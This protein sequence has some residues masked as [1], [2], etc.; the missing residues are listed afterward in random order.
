MQIY[1]IH[2]QS[3]KTNPPR[4]T[5]GC[6]IVSTR[7]VSEHDGQVFWYGSQSVIHSWWNMWEHLGLLDSHTLSPLLKGLSHNLQSGR[8]GGFPLVLIAGLSRLLMLWLRMRCNILVGVE[9][10]G[11]SELSSEEASAPEPAS[12]S[13]S[14]VA[15]AV[16][17]LS[18][19]STVSVISSSSIPSNFLKS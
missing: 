5:K 11:A 4:W 2:H 17:E 15:G 13:L 12:I 14:N 19:C 7:N 10:F 8:T 18:D 3:K 1:T 6:Y 9:L 16:N